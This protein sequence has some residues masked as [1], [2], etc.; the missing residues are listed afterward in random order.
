M[1]SVMPKVEGKEMSASVKQLIRWIS[2]TN[3]SR[4]DAGFDSVQ[5][6]DA[7]LTAYYE[8]GYRL[9]ASHYLGENPEGY[10]VLYV[11]VHE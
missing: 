9:F 7:E 8:L 1:Q 2:K 3:V 4:A 10:G 6:I 11:L 5:S